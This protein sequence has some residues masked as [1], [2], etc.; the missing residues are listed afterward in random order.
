MS[1]IESKCQWCGFQDRDKQNGEHHCK[2]YMADQIA[3]L[4]A[5]L[6]T[7][8]ATCA[9]LVTSGNAIQ[10]AENLVKVSIQN[11]E[12]QE[13]MERSDYNLELCAKAHENAIKQRDVAL[14]KSEVVILAAKKLDDAINE[15]ALGIDVIAASNDLR[16]ALSA[17]SDSPPNEMV[18]A[19]T[20][21]LPDEQCD[22]WHWN[23]DEDSAPIHVSVF[24]SGGSE[25]YFL[26]AG[27]YGW[28]EPQDCKSLGGY[29]MKDET[30]NSPSRE[31]VEAIRTQSK[32]AWHMK[33]ALELISDEK[34]R[35]SFK[36]D[37]RHDDAHKDQIMAMTASR[38]C[39]D[40]TDI[41]TLDDQWGLCAKHRNN[42]IHQLV[43]AGNLICAE[44][45]RLQ[46]L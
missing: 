5:N 42:R 29:W 32:K 1:E 8:Q 7:C 22:Y 12:S 27:Q 15:P 24:Y 4:E 11:Q 17:L 34:I 9:E 45:E 39:A 30:P 28:T 14:K 21:R 37:A 19:W 33:T 46:R 31:T 6:A 13:K 41:L 43:V 40:G 23:G 3:T 16:S 35:S 25:S 18:S 38:L 36:Y 26:P 2:S 10:L 44:I 20:D